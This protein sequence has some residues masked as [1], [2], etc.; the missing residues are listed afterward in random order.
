M[1]E[2]KSQMPYYGFDSFQGLREPWLFRDKLLELTMNYDYSESEIQRA[3][4]DSLRGLGRFLRGHIIFVC[5]EK[6]ITR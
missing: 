5:Y 2:R 3:Q 6:L 4:M 1:S